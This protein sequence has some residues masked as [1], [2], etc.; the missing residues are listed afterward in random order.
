MDAP[1][2]SSSLEKCFSADHALLDLMIKWVI[3]AVDR[4]MSSAEVARLFAE[5]E[6]YVLNHMETEE[7]YLLSE[8][9]RVREADAKALLVEHARL[10]DRMAELEER[11]GRGLLS[12]IDL[13]SMAK[14]LDAHSLR[15]EH[16]LHVWSDDALSLPQLSIIL[17]YMSAVAKRR[18]TRSVSG[19]FSRA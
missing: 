18:A 19:D 3:D 17:R 8:L 9:I 10:R 2:T 12:V 14:E 11:A 15:E 13:R 7:T 6:R 16:A 1:H 4:R 5:C